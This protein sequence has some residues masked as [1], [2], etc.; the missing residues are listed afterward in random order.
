[1]GIASRFKRLPWL[2]AVLFDNARS[3]NDVVTLALPKDRSGAGITPVL[4]TKLATLEDPAGGTYEM[5]PTIRLFVVSG[6]LF[7]LGGTLLQQLNP[8]TAEVPPPQRLSGCLRA[9]DAAV[10]DEKLHILCLSRAQGPD[11]PYQSAAKVISPGTPVF[12]LLE[13]TYA[14]GIRERSAIVTDLVSLTAQGELFRGEGKDG[15]RKILL[16]DLHANHAS[17]IMELGINNVEGRV[18]W[19]QIYFLNGL[20]D[21]L[22][23]A[24]SD[25]TAADLWQPILSLARQ[26]LDLEIH[27]LDRLMQS[28][29]GFRTKAF[30]VGREPAIF[31]V[32]TS[33]L[34][35][36][37]NR[38]SR[39]FPE[40]VTI[41]SLPQLSRT[42]LRLDGHIDVLTTAGPDSVE[43]EPGRKYLHWP[44]GSAFYFDGLNVPYNHQNEW[45]YAVFDTL[46]DAPAA[47]MAEQDALAAST[48]IIIQ[49]LGAIAPQGEMPASGMWPYWW[50]KAREGWTADQGISRNRPD[51]PGDRLTAWMSFRS[52]D[53]M[54]VL[55]ASPHLA[56]A[57]ELALRNSIAAL[58]HAGLV[59]PF[60][61][62]GFDSTEQL[63]LPNRAAALAYGRMT[64]PSDLQNAVYAYYTLARSR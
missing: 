15:L 39:L 22:S 35:L 62:A 48:D 7:T 29:F 44:N 51:Y 58:V 41:A 23:L 47:D 20:M 52:I 28:E 53:V 42:V 5:I 59:Y 10:V 19:S 18:A 14:D 55:A 2:V 60:V 34:L 9:Q 4:H 63:P 11:Q 31:A 61:A 25:E 24:L 30:T 54:S 3:A 16:D 56:R 38:Y 49:F 64:A 57:R 13:Y 32:Q 26:R 33:R 27:L 46:K 50:G 17:G 40:G 43:P 37:F 21:L 12:R 1:M 36:L 6:R 8:G 45:A